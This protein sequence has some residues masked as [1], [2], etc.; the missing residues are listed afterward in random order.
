MR[1]LSPV[2]LVALLAGSPCRG[3]DD[4]LGPRNFVFF[5]VERERIRG[6]DFLETDALVGAQLKYTWRELE[7]E[8]GRYELQPVLDDLR[9]LEAHG[10]RLFVQLQDVSFDERINVPNYLIEDPAYGGG[11]ARKYEFEGDDESRPVFD[12]WVARRWDPA[13]IDRFK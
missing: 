1:M 3:G 8:P 5:N 6:G 2:L 4:S 12:G 10:K 7:P 9:F 11:V 13:V